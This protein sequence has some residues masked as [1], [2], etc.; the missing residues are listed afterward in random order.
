MRTL[1]PRTALPAGDP[2]HPHTV[3]SSHHAAPA[4]PL[5]MV[6]QAPQVI[7]YNIKGCSK[8]EIKVDIT[9]NLTEIAFVGVGQLVCADPL[10]G[11][12][13]ISGHDAT[14][15]GHHIFWIDPFA[16]D[17]TKATTIAKIAAPL[18]Y[19]LGGSCAVDWDS[20]VCAAHL[21]ILI[22]SLRAQAPPASP[23]TH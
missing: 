6:V 21:C 3:P 1:S 8:G 11:R 13:I 7:G 20:K 23:R 10:T 9:L 12:L 14:V 22:A 5:A 17:P 19:L 18:V 16:A 15:Q 2:S 4:L